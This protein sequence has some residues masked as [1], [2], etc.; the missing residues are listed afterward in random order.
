MHFKYSKRKVIF[1][2]FMPL[3]FVLMVFSGI[4][5]ITQSKGVSPD[6]ASITFTASVN[7]EGGTAYVGTASGSGTSTTITTSNTTVYFWGTASTG[8]EISSFN[9]GGYENPIS[10]AVGASGSLPEVCDYTISGTKT[11]PQL[12][13]RNFAKDT[14]VVFN[15]T[16]TNYTLTAT[17]AN[18][19]YGTGYVSSNATPSGTLSSVSSNIS[20]SYAV[21]GTANGDANCFT[22][23]LSSFTLTANGATYNI[24]A[25]QSSTI[26]GVATYVASNDLY[27]PML[28]L[29]NIT[30]NIS[31]TINYTYI[32]FQ[33]SATSNN[34]SLGTSKVGTSSSAITSDIINVNSSGTYYAIS[35][36]TTD[37]K[38]SRIIATL[39]GISKTNGQEYTYTTEKTLTSANVS[40]TWQLGSGSNV[41]SLILS[42]TGFSGSLTITASK[43]SANL[44]LQ[45]V[46]EQLNYDLNDGSTVVMLNGNATYSTTFTGSP[47]VPT[48]EVIYANQTLQ[49]GTHYSVSI[50]SNT[51]AG[52]ARV[53]ITGLSGGFFKGT[54]IKEFTIYPKNIASNDITIS[55]INSSYAYQ[56]TAIRPTPV[57]VDTSRGTNPIA[58]GTDYTVSYGTNINAGINVGYVYITGKGNYANSSTYRTFTITQQDITNATNYTINGTLNSTYTGSAITPKPE[59]IIVRGFTLT[60]V[61][62]NLT[63]N[64]NLNAGT[65]TM[66]VTAKANGNFTGSFTVQFNIAQA[67]ISSVEVH[68]VQT[69]YTYTGSAIYPENIEI[70]LGSKKLSINTDY[71]ISYGANTEVST[72]GSVTITAGTGGNFTG[73]KVVTFTISEQSI[74]NVTISSVSGSFTYNGSQHTPKLNLSYNGKTLIEN[75]DYSYRYLNNTNAGVATVIVD[76]L[77]NFYQSATKEFVIQ[78]KAI[79]SSSITVDNISSK[80]YT[81]T[82]ISPIEEVSNAVRD[83]A[84]GESGTLLVNGVD[85]DVTFSNNTNAGQAQITITGKNNYSGTRPTIYFTIER[86]NIS[87]NAT[88]VFLSGIEATYE[89]T[90]TQIRPVPAGVNITAATGESHILNSSSYVLS[91]GTNLEVGDDDAY[92]QITG[93]GNYQGSYKQNFGI[94]AKPLDS[95]SITVTYNETGYTY[96]K[97][98]QSVSNLVVKNG[99]I[100]LSVDKDY[101]IRYSNHINAGTAYFTIKGIGNYSSEITRSFTISPLAISSDIT[102]VYNSETAIGTM[103]KVYNGTSFQIDI[104]VFDI[105]GDFVEQVNNYSVQ[106]TR[107]G[108][109]SG[110]MTSAGTVLISVTAEGNYTGQASATFIITPLKLT[111]TTVMIDSITSATFTGFELTPSFNVKYRDSGEIIPD[112]YYTYT[113]T[114]NI[115]AGTNARV[116]VT[117]TGNYSGTIDR[118]FTISPKS[119]SH[120]SVV[121]GELDREYFYNGAPQQPKPVITDNSRDYD[122]IEGIDFDF[123]YSNNTNAGSANIIINGKGNYSGTQTTTFT[124]QQLTITEDMIAPIENQVYTGSSIKPLP[125]VTHIINGQSIV[126]VNGTHYTLSYSNN[127]SA[128]SEATVTVSGMGDYG[129]NATVSFT[130][131]PYSITNVIY[132][133]I[134]NQPFQNVELTPN[135]SLS[136]N[137]QALTEGEDADYTARFE[138]NFNVGTARIIIEGKNNFSGTRT[139]TFEITAIDVSSTLINAE[140]KESS[141]S[142]YNQYPYVGNAALKTYPY[143]QSQ[144]TPYFELVYNVNGQQVVLVPNVDFTFNFQN[145]VEAGTST[146]PFATIN[147]TGARNYTGSTSIEFT[148][149]PKNISDAD[150]VFNNVEDQPF[151]GSERKPA[152]SATYMGNEYLSGNDAWW[153]DISYSNNIDKG[154]GQ[155]LVTGKG[156]LTGSKTLSFNIVQASLSDA[157]VVLEYTETIYNTATQIPIVTVTI[158]DGVLQSGA[159]YIYTIYQSSDTQFT[160]PITNP[161][162]AGSYTV[163]I[164][165]GNDNENFTGQLTAEYEILP[166]DL[167]TQ[168][169][170]L[171]TVLNSIKTYTGSKIE[172]VASDLDVSYL[173]VDLILG[174]D[175]TLSYPVDPITSGNYAVHI[176]GMANY[177][178][179]LVRWFSIVSEALDSVTLVTS[180]ITYGDSTTEPVFTV[181]S[182]GKVVTKDNYTATWTRD[183][184]A[185]TDF[186]SAGTLKLSVTGKL[187]YM[188]TVTTNYVINPRNVSELTYQY[189]NTAEYTGSE[190]KPSVTVI[191]QGAT[192]SEGNDYFLTYTNNINVG[193]MTGIIQITGTGNFTDTITKNFS[194]TAFSVENLTYRIDSASNTT[195]TGSRITPSIAVYFNDTTLLINTVD[196]TISYGDNINAGENAGQIYITGKGNFA[197]EHTVNFTILQRSLNNGIIAQNIQD[198]TFTGTQIMPIPVL[199]DNIAGGKTLISG[200]DYSIAYGE[201]INAGSLAGSI[202]L[203]GKNNYNDNLT[204]RFNILTRAITDSTISIEIDDSE[205]IY[206]GYNIEAPVNVTLNLTSTPVELQVGVD[207]VVTYSNNI[208]AGENAVA[209]VQGIGNYSGRTTELL[210]TIAKR[211]INDEDNIVFA[212]IDD[213]QYT[214]TYITPSLQIAHNFGS[215]PV[216]YLVQNSDFIAVY[217]NN[218]NV[219]TST[220]ASVE[221][222]GQG[223]YEGVKTVY[224]KI[225]EREITSASLNFSSIIYDMMEHKP[226]KSNLTVSSEGTVAGTE[227]TYD[228]AEYQRADELGNYSTTDDFISSGTIRIVLNGT[229]NFNGSTYTEFTITQKSLADEDIS[230]RLYYM[231]N[232][233][234][235]YFTVQN[236]PGVQSYVEIRRYFPASDVATLEGLGYTVITESSQYYVVLQEDDDYI[237][238][239]SRTDALNTDSDFYEKAGTMNVE[240]NGSGSYYSST[241][242]NYN[243][244]PQSIDD[245]DGK[246][247]VDFTDKDGTKDGLAYYT[248]NNTNIQPTLAISTVDGT[249][250]IEN[251]DFTVSNHI[252]N[253]NVGIATLTITGI[254]NFSGTLTQNYLIVE[255][256]INETDV[257]FFTTEPEPTYIYSGKQIM[258]EIVLSSNIVGDLVAGKDITIS[259]GTNLNCGTGSVTITGKG[260][261]TGTITKE[262]QILQKAISDSDIVVSGILESYTYTGREIEPTF[263]LTYNSIVDGATYNLTL[264]A[265]A[266][267][268]YTYSYSNNTSFGTGIITVNANENGNYTGTKT[269]P[270]TIANVALSYMIVNNSVVTYTGYA[271]DIS[272]NVMNVN[273]MQV[274]PNEYDL[275]YYRA[276]TDTEGNFVYSGVATPYDE[277]DRTSWG[278]IRIVATAKSTGNFSGSVTGYFNIQKRN[279]NDTGISVSGINQYNVYTGLEITFPISISLLGNYTLSDNIDYI[280]TY[281]NNKNVGTAKVTFQ[282]Q[283]NFTGSISR[284]FTITQLNINDIPEDNLLFEQ[285]YD[286]QY[287]GQEIT[288][289]TLTVSF[290]PNGSQEDK[291]ILAQDVDFTLVYENNINAGTARMLFTFNNNIVGSK[292]Q[293]FNISRKS[294][295]SAI[296]TLDNNTFTYDGSAKTPTPTVVLDEITLVYNQDYTISYQN[297]INAKNATEENAPIIIITGAGNYSE[298]AW[299]QFTILQKDIED[300][301][302]S[303]S[304][305]LSQIYTG[306]PIHP[307]SLT[308][309][310]NAATITTHRLTMDLDYNLTY[311]E[312]TN[313]G[314]GIINING[315][316]N[317]TGTRTVNF[318]IQPITISNDNIYITGINPTYSYTGYQ[319]TP[320]PTSVIVTNGDGQ[321]LTLTAVNDYEISYGPNLDANSTGRIYFTGTGNYIGSVERTFQ[322]NNRSISSVNITWDTSTPYEYTGTYVQLKNLKVTDG[323]LELEEGKDFVVNYRDNINV[324]QATVIITGMGNYDPNS[325]AYAYFQIEKLSISPELMLNQ[326]GSTTAANYLTVNFTG[327]RINVDVSVY[328][329]NG[330]L[331]SPDEFDILI[332]RNGTPESEFIQIGAITYTYTAKENSNYTGT[333]VGYLEICAI[334]ISNDVTFSNLAANPVYTGYEITPNFTIYWNGSALSQDSYTG[335]YMNNVNAGENTAYY[336][337]TFKGNFAGSATKYFT[338]EPKTLGTSIVIQN[339]NSYIYTGN[340]ITPTFDIY[341]NDRSLTLTSGVDYNT[342][343]TDNIN[344][345]NA[346]ITITGNGNYKGTKTFEF[347]ILPLAITEDMIESIASEV[348]NGQQIRPTVV[349][350]FNNT[351]LVL[352]QDY[353][354]R[355][356]NN[357]NIGIAWVT[358]SGMNNFTSSAQVSFNI[359]AHD[360]NNAVIQEIPNY[361]YNYGNSIEPT[362]NI[363]CNGASL[364]KD[365][366]YTVIYQKNIDA[367]EAIVT[368]NGMGNYQDVVTINFTILPLTIDRDMVSGITKLTFNGTEQTQQ[369]ILVQD[370]EYVLKPDID[371]IVTYED[372]KNAGQATMTFRGNQNF[373]GEF[374]YTFEIEKL[375]LE[376]ALLDKAIIIDPIPAQAYTGKPVKPVPTITLRNTTGSYELINEIDFT[377]V[378]DTEQTNVGTK[379]VEMRGMG[380]YIGVISTTYEIQ[381]MSLTKLELLESVFIYNMSSQFPAVQ[382]YAGEALLTLGQDYDY[383][384]L[385]N[386]LEV[387]ETISVGEYEIEVYAISSNFSGSLKQT[388]TIT[389]KDITT[390]GITVTVKLDS[391]KN[392]TGQAITLSADEVEVKHGTTTL[393]MG[394]D[395]YLSYDEGGAIEAGVHN[396]TFNGMNNYFG[397]VIRTFQIVSKA[398][399]EITFSITEATYNRQAHSFNYTV[400]SGDEVVTTG[401]NTNVTPTSDVDFVW[402]RNGVETVDFTSAGTIRLTATGKHNYMGTIFK[403]FVILPYNISNESNS[404]F[405]F[406]TDH[407]YT[408]TDIMPT[409]SKATVLGAELDASADYNLRYANNVNAGNNAQILV[410]GKGN[411]TGTKI[412]YFTIQKRNLSDTLYGINADEN[413]TYTG[414]AI[415]PNINITYLSDTLEINSDFT[416]TYGENI[417]AGENAGSINIFAVETSNY[418]G[419]VQIKF[420]IQAKNI[421]SAVGKIEIPAHTYTGTKIEPTFTLKDIARDVELIKDTDYRVNY[422]SNITAGTNA[423]TIVITGTNNY[424][425]VINLTFNITS[426]T[427]DDEFEITVDESQCIY[428]GYQLTPNITIKLDSYTLA[429]YT[430]YTIKYG[431]NINVETGGTVTIT[432]TGNFIGT[433]EYNFEI[434]PKT[435]SNDDPTLSIVDIPTQ[436]YTG[437]NITPVFTVTYQYN[438]EYS[439]KTL[440]ENTD[441]TVTYDDNINVGTVT[442]TLTGKGNYIGSMTKEFSII[443]RPL[444]R[445]M[446]GTQNYDYNMLEH[447]PADSDLT[448]VADGLLQGEVT[449]V[450][451]QY[452]RQNPET[453][454]WQ[455]TDDFISAGNIR[456]IVEG[457]NNF[458]GEV[459]VDYTINPKSIQGADISI[460]IY[461]LDENNQRVYIT[462]QTYQGKR[463]YVELR[464]IFSGAEADALGDLLQTDENG[465]KYYVLSSP[466]DYTSIFQKLNEDSVANDNS[467][468]EPGTMNISVTGVNNYTGSKNTSYNIYPQMLTNDDLSISFTD[469]AGT[470]N[471]IPYYIYT[472]SNIQPQISVTLNDTNKTPLYAGT[473]YNVVSYSNNTNVGFASILL[474]FTSLYQGEV[475]VT[476]QIKPL[477]LQTMQADTDSFT[478][479]QIS[480]LVFNGIQ[481]KPVPAISYN[482]YNLKNN[483]DFILNYENNVNRGTATVY[484]TGTGNYTDTITTTFNITP[485]SLGNGT[486]A[487]DGISATNIENQTY[488]GQEIRP[489]VS[490]IFNSVV[491]GITYNIT[492]TPGENFDYTVAYSNNTSVG[493]ATITFTA[494]DNG[495]YSGAFQTTFIIDK[496]PLN[497]LSISNSVFTYSGESNNN[498]FEI[499]VYDNQNQLVDNSTNQYKIRYY[500]GTKLSTG[501]Y[502]FNEFVENIYQI[503]TTNVGKVKVEVVANDSSNYSGSLEGFIEILPYNITGTDITITGITSH[504]YYNG[505]YEIT[506]PIVVSFRGTPRNEQTEQNPDGDYTVEYKSNTDVGEATVII[507]GVNNFEGTY[508]TT[509]EILPFNFTLNQ[510]NLQITNVTDLTYTGLPLEQE[511]MVLYYHKDGQ[512]DVELKEDIDYTLNYTNNTYAGTANIEITF[513]GNYEGLAN[514]NFEILGASIGTAVIAL[515]PTEFVYDG[516]AKNPNI[517]V[518]LDEKQLI[519]NTDYTVEISNN[520]NAGN[521]SVVVRGINNYADSATTTFTIHKKPLSEVFVDNVVDKV[522]T[523]SAITQNP[524]ISFIRE[525]GSEAILI[526]GDDYILSYKDNTR[527]GVAKLIITATERN[528]TGS[529]EVEFNITPLDINNRN[530]TIDPINEQTFTTNDITPSVIVRKDGNALDL[531]DYEIIFT[532]NKNVG[533]ATVTIN[534]R[535]NYQGTRETSFNIVAKRLDDTASPRV[536][537]TEFSGTKTFTG[538][539]VELIYINQE[540]NGSEDWNKNDFILTYNSVN[541]LKGTDFTLSYKNNIN[542]GIATVTITGTGNYIN[543][544]SFDFTINKKELTADMIT[545][546]SEIEADEPQW[547]FTGTQITPS[548]TVLD[549]ERNLTLQ[550]GYDY[551]VD[552]GENIVVGDGYVY[553]TVPE[554]SNYTISTEDKR[555]TKVFKIVQKLITSVVLESE[556]YEYTGSAIVPNMQVYTSGN[557][558]PLIIDIDYKVSIVENS[559]INVAE[560]IEITV[561]GIGNYQGIIV[562]TF[563]IIPRS[564]KDAKIVID[565]SIENSVIYSGNEFTPVPSIV[566]NS[567]EENIITLQPDIDFTVEY[568]DNTNAGT[569]V[570]TITGKGNFKDTLERKFTIL[571]YTITDSMISNFEETV[572][573]ANKNI[574]QEFIITHEG[575]PKPTLERNV[576]YNVVY[577]TQNRNVGI[578]RFTI[579]GQGNYDGTITKQFEIIAQ[580]INRNN[581][582]I[583]GIESNVIYTGQSYNNLPITVSFI[584]AENT[585]RELLRGTDYDYTYSEDTVNA[586]Q[587][588]ITFTFQNNYSGTFIVSFIIEPKPITDDMVSDP[589]KQVYTGSRITPPITVVYGEMTLVED[590]DYTITYRDNVDLGTASAIITAK[591]NSNYSGT[592]TRYFE[593]TQKIITSIDEFNYEFQ[594][595]YTY[596][597]YEITPRIETLTFKDTN[598]TLTA[599]TDYELGWINNRDALNDARVRLTFL[600]GYSGTIYVPFTINPAD[601]N[602]ARFE[603]ISDTVYNGLEQKLVPSASFGVFSLINNRQFIITYPED[604]TN[605]GLKVLTISGTGN[606][607]GTYTASTISYNILQADLSTTLDVKFQDGFDYSYT[608]SEIK[609]PVILN[610]LTLTLSDADVDINYYNN[611]NKGPEAVVVISANQDKNANFI[612][613]K[614]VNFE[615]VSK[616]LH[617]GLIQPIVDQYYDG[618]EKKPEIVLKDGDY[619]LQQ[620][621]DKDFI[622]VYLDNINAGQASILVT[623]AVNYAGTL[624]IHFNILPRELGTNGVPNSNVF[625]NP[626]PIPEQ[627]FTNSEIKPEFELSYGYDL[628]QKDIDYEVA[629][630]NN[631]YVGNNATITITGIG[632]YKGVI[633]YQF[634]IVPCPISEV[635]ISEL[636]TYYYTGSPVEPELILI[637]EGTELILGQDYTVVYFNNIAASTNLASIVITGLGNYTGSITIRFDIL[638]LSITDLVLPISSIV[639]D[640][641]EKYSYIQNVDVYCNNSLLDRQYYRIEY[642]RDGVATTDFIS[643]GTITVKVTAGINYTGTLEQPFVI[644]PKPLTD[645]DIT[646]SNT[647]RD[648]SYTGQPITQ[649]FTITHIIGAMNKTLIEQTDT[650]IGDY[651]VSYG[652]NNVDVGVVIMTITGVNNYSGF[653][654]RTF[655]ITKITPTVN[656]YYDGET[657]F[658]GSATPQLKLS[659]GDTPGTVTLL[660]SVLTAGTKEYEWLFVPT[661]TVNYFNLS[662]TIR[663]IAQEVKIQ[664][665]E[666]VNLPNKTTYYAFEYF[667]DE[668][669]V[670]NA[671][672][673]NGT[674]EPITNYQIQ[675]NVWLNTQIT[676]MTI[677]CVGLTID[678][679][680]TVLPREITVEFSNYENLLESDTARYVNYVIN[681]E[682][683]GYPVDAEIE[684]VHNGEVVDGITSAGRYTVSVKLPISTNYVFANENVLNVDVKYITLQSENV[685]AIDEKG[686]DVGV[687]LIV[688][689][690]TDSILM[691]EYI[692][693]LK[694]TPDAIYI[695]KLVDAN[696]NEVV[697]TRDIII[698]IITN[699]PER[700]NLAIYIKQDDGSFDIQRFEVFDDSLQFTTNDLSEYTVGVR[701]IVNNFLAISWWWLLLILIAVALLIELIVVFAKRNRTK[702]IGKHKK[703]NQTK[704]K[705]TK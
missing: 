547:T 25:G 201:N 248:F 160:T 43:I 38:L 245:F 484:I 95:T 101:E 662:G 283:G 45:F 144:I 663:L 524:T 89:Y 128:S 77:G 556:N 274:D 683:E 35:T 450:I 458:Q 403:E 72:G 207:F 370:G 4:N 12:T 361:Y 172:L 443:E 202:I 441:F 418:T 483:T 261:F 571:K 639:Y 394:T 212:D 434:T 701:I 494:T 383:R 365:V 337:V 431:E 355:Y 404:A 88:N 165:P 518:T 536:I 330:G 339:L 132:E 576:D 678:I 396:V 477:S 577:L 279:L 384:L 169:G 263:Q 120:S 645:T 186:T 523:G 79:T 432:G 412:L 406:P 393:K 368:I 305:V 366:D 106:R 498:N 219:T 514:Q 269:I 166:C 693:E 192:L 289:P 231:A 188:G 372:N 387:N 410:N 293:Q 667:D 462:E 343:I 139:V 481:Q 183:G 684:Y 78:P 369:N 348:Y 304:N 544:L 397:Q 146:N 345:G 375:N 70:Y 382:V 574:D 234:K 487:A 243:I 5:F 660:E 463:T 310:D 582:L 23:Q 448:V 98:E 108:A 658:A 364:Q 624:T 425:G 64:N 631:I 7:G 446:L 475:Q 285:I 604:V 554:S 594:D 36:P 265:G 271:F 354:V 541:L 454:E 687:N 65:A 416:V 504:V 13:I 359:T 537:L 390:A 297:H 170:V 258:P 189:N 511:N 533:K 240:V 573:F 602:S 417:N 171:A 61:D 347:Q 50:S 224:F 351:T 600:G 689:K 470:E 97:L 677:S 522:Y 55:G 528:Y 469:A 187:N 618:T 526:S 182:N 317:Y 301:T 167:S 195:Y 259:Y 452:Q 299:L 223:N 436:V 211:N 287:T 395:F 551:L 100:Q 625:I 692:G 615:I 665:V 380:N 94:V 482:G 610:F 664:N 447:K 378:Y 246:L 313:V 546:S 572:T 612:G 540:I 336:A 3:L 408:T 328:D 131:L 444:T 641:Q 346:K 563:N 532:N 40:E 561:T 15:Y 438:T 217:Q 597:G 180:N 699:A 190:I 591:R 621:E 236:Y 420:N 80:I 253:L 616:S 158:F 71:L 312:N 442:A 157:T 429:Q 284:N 506:Q 374:Q 632:N 87:T 30:S 208:R 456:I 60:D 472:G 516:S 228:I 676:K 381:Q 688:T 48:V 455:V 122:L 315:M 257:V 565:T 379:K 555:V 423:G 505:G 651:V 76:G 575:N 34:A 59:S 8:Y 320:I 529:L 198:Q 489:S 314:Q 445:A 28:I 659:E 599:G 539:E 264:L 163:V 31:V 147:I 534:G 649:N 335:T 486:V 588:D 401:I 559:N 428:T 215:M 488:T 583:T 592:I 24:A 648:F 319:I 543:E 177:S 473:H 468:I 334:D 151:T 280:T 14:I 587:V 478:L 205:T 117:F 235:T 646:M 2:I 705:S 629:Y 300:N 601:I 527:V 181:M 409:L 673:N 125:V 204:I 141:E 164:T 603:A 325:S 83:S 54:Y 568:A 344:A 424:S 399:T 400:M 451:K 152:F 596:T 260:N 230:L 584:E 501:E 515:E 213:Q 229:G 669:L 84:I 356:D 168:N 521:A 206:T 11:N 191:F 129:G 250:L 490:V 402:S 294:L 611:I 449:F 20:G 508:E 650:Q 636:G 502:I 282:G 63:Y 685:I 500:Q 607:T 535:N 237:V 386:S 185:T 57:V 199:I 622:A 255:Q 332:T 102:L 331:V 107:N 136:F 173:G 288:Q 557:N 680:I 503:N 439:A 21:F 492:L 691:Q 619:I 509:F 581:S 566:F 153:S 589:G 562:E 459:Y 637:R 232:D 644:E 605:V 491:E 385:H 590:R 411:F 507:T 538:S 39:T 585:Y 525:N 238:N 53:T 363:T 220:L 647:I 22:Y 247:I 421:E 119:V 586:G 210:W 135:L 52:T 467:F 427:I 698:R 10:F 74:Q 464:R 570:V 58:S 32:T 154:V 311:G 104:R 111:A 558:T 548:I 620:G 162:N 668:G 608:G 627:S 695:I 362:L 353:S 512:E 298:T 73:S 42:R 580:E 657:L 138:N 321:N 1:S 613:E 628:L 440:T 155:I 113:Y 85:Y 174:Q 6:A 209:I 161:T 281:E 392:Y 308:V 681:G 530:I 309:T 244:I 254:S 460:L 16:Y 640:T 495:N 145:N 471:G 435:L 96:N 103:S 242:T 291:I 46:Y 388:Y 159:D 233:V 670:L 140:I 127:I 352:E 407:T 519:Y 367:G 200:Q 623:G 19:A 148:I 149:I 143:T 630:S 116:V 485:K 126:L 465:Q 674:V 350:K 595:A 179:T 371:Y 175:F 130:I 66:T 340:T 326:T 696:G 114:N 564:L 642:L 142:P 703:N 75:Q 249:T 29:S 499:L 666:I 197:G 275:T 545:I 476:F 267:Y 214:G 93:T 531:S 513:K 415:K 497:Y 614:R 675:E 115:N 316:G 218:I 318:E 278:Q 690:I 453:L 635:T 62:Y 466:Q 110:D 194:I 290:L 203:T 262:F 617:S 51:N 26:S 225:V 150:F 9:I 123:D 241:Q 510:T 327:S 360:I 679:P 86:F 44:V 391:P 549:S 91:Y 633:T 133:N 517:T 292:T 419:T 672:Y 697:L 342:G 47:I 296:I 56:G 479:G 322:I 598:K 654:E 671:V 493:E 239:F 92:V 413:T 652:D 437:T 156:N 377:C 376:Q 405:A 398:L 17:S 338:I 67:N 496:R 349:V 426:R 277:L 176:D 655:N 27:N 700:Q 226:D 358:V 81:G 118:S 333:A 227:I 105:N 329:K 124:I 682:I 306:A 430:D 634:S 112:T 307:T 373:T 251:E 480:D 694:V 49:E 553:V 661:D 256:D 273:G 656:P 137:N 99:N 579:I 520:V 196:Y 324:G 109:V 686:F 578:V 295:A 252:N 606:F 90:G 593:I 643:A 286:A 457:T 68:N 414:S 542:A 626:N 461:I 41:P 222:T 178:G 653:I 18:T 389:Q 560:N 134:P 121:I 638:P 184:E 270:F 422:G 268:D 303:I 266:N 474:N 221:V 82:Q 357:I 550:L 569:A 69:D 276:T 341:D 272:V 323:Q 702:K 433:K 609:P 37:Y 193:S 552:Y 567:S 302:I 216:R 33:F 704:Q